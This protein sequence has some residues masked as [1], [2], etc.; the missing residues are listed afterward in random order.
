MADEAVNHEDI[1]FYWDNPDKVKS[2]DDILNMMN[3]S[4]Q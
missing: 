4:V 3:K 1:D 2:K